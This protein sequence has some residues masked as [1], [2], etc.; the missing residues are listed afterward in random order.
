MCVSADIC[1]QVC[2][3][4]FF[5]KKKVWFCFSIMKSSNVCNIEVFHNTITQEIGTSYKTRIDIMNT[6]HQY[7]NGD[8]LLAFPY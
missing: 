6:T 7:V 1:P 8:S 4:D 5:Q 2:N 3:P